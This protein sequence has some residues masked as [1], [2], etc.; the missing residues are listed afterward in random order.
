MALD[1]RANT[2]LD[3]LVTLVHPLILHLDMAVNSIDPL[4]SLSYDVFS[5]LSYVSSQI[6]IDQL[7]LL[8]RHH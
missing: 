3:L 6:K 5:L 8:Y 7:A 2:L 4:L 1:H